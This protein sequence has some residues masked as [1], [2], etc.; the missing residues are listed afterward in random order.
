MTQEMRDR[1]VAVLRDPQS[2][3]ARYGFS[4]E[5]DSH[6]ALGWLLELEQ[7]TD[8]QRVLQY[9]P[10]GTRQTLYTMNDYTGYSLP[11]I[12]DW[13]EENVEVTL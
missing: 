10:N 11:K 6:C 13:I 2:K 3:Q 1:W 4:A 7:S 5:D 8:P 9:V 12:A